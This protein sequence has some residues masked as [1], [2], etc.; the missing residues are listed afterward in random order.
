MLKLDLEQLRVHAS[1]HFIPRQTPEAILVK[2]DEIIAE[3][4]I[5][6]E[7][8]AKRDV[9]LPTARKLFDRICNLAFGDCL[10]G[11]TAYRLRGAQEIL[12]AAA[13][14]DWNPSHF[15]DTAEMSATVAIGLGWFTPV[16]RSS[17][18]LLVL[19]AI[20]QKGLYPAL[21]AVD[22][23]AF[24]LTAR[25]NW[26]IVCC[27]AMV[28]SALAI[29][30]HDAP[31]AAK[32]ID[33]FVPAMRSGLEGFGDDGGYEEGPAYWE[34]AVRYTALAYALLMQEGLI[35]EVPAGIRN[36]WRFGRD[37]KGPSGQDFNFGDNT[38]LSR[39]SPVLGWLAKI[40]KEPEAAQW[41]RDAAGEPS[42]LDL[43]WRG[44]SKPVNSAA[45]YLATFEPAG[46]AVLRNRHLWAGIKAGRNDVN[47]AHLDLGSFVFEAGERRFVSDLGRDDYALPGYFDPSQRFS[48]FRTRTEAHSTLMFDGL[49]QSREAYSLRIGTDQAPDALS[50]AYQIVEPSLEHVWR[51]GWILHDDRLIVVDEIEFPD[52][53]PA[54]DLKWQ[55]YT[56]AAVDLIGNTAELSHGNR[57]VRVKIATPMNVN[58][59]QSQPATGDGQFDNSSFTCLCFKI[60]VRQT[61]RL[62]VELLTPGASPLM[63]I[64]P[65]INKWGLH[66]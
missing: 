24:W 19:S 62:Q 3:P 5:A 50:A 16:M 9:I 21:T 11:G 46:M 10:A 66:V 20:I 36:T 2:C 12:Q 25:H 29:R 22:D 31:L 64:L 60:T 1:D 65:A 26:N 57:M 58:W 61:I 32:I 27:S 48:Y 49:Q 14:P 33:N 44:P 45:S 54:H 55:L 18:R 38:I 43:L 47:H 40:S 37:S 52:P 56:D 4:L 42:P 59:E 53:S 6:V 23:Q 7:K 63:R 8:E 17:D 28:I 39:R 13:F 51:R 35:G 34:F 30:C 15:L 41:Q